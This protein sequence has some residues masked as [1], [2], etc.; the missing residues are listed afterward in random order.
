MKNNS[1]KIKRSQTFNAL[2]K[3][4]RIL[5]GSN[6]TYKKKLD[7]FLSMIPDAPKSGSGGSSYISVDLD[8]QIRNWNWALRSY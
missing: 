5:D 6:N 2:P 8:D 3:H 1:C 7:E 4:L